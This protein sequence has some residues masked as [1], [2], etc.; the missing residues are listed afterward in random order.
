MALV[1]PF[2]GVR[3]RPDLAAEV[4]APPYDVLNEEEARAIVARL[5]H[6]F[7]RVTRPEVNL[8]RGVDAHSAEAYG[9]ARAALLGMLD[10]GSLVQDDEP[11]FYLYGQRMGTHV[12]TGLLAVCSTAEYDDGV[13]KKHEFT[14]PD[15]EQDRVDHILGTGAQTGLVFLTYRQT[16]RLAQLL[17]R[18]SEAP[19]YAV[20]TD[21]DVEHLLWRIVDPDDVAAIGAAFA[22]LDALY[23]AD[24]HHRSAAASRVAAELGEGASEWF[25]CGIFPDDQLQVLAY[26]RLVADLNGHGAEAFVAAV[27][28]HFEVADADGGVP[29]RRGDVHMF[30]DGGWKRLR[31]RA[32]TASDDPVADL[33]VA[34]LQDT[35]LAPLLGIQDPRRDTRIRFV[36]GIRGPDAL[37]R[38]VRAGEA[39]VAFHL[40]PTSLAE[41]F[42]VADSGQ[43]MPPKSTW[44]EPKLRG[45]VVVHKLR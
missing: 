29:A 6:S 27:S 5:P 24:G 19:L 38:A 23:I 14:R 32:S 41:L 25:L 42:S 26:N 37:E 4:V 9:A 31:R 45:G 36:G 10:D 43:V 16:E 13:I 20:T 35:V 21:D 44:F 8:A 17:A 33:D 28:A 15:K 40:Y 18:P 39:A 22:E 12:Q 34:V 1:R 3:A 11:C 7:L 30:L 2:R